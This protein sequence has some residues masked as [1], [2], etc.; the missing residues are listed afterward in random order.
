MSVNEEYFMITM[1]LINNLGDE[2]WINFS[3][4]FTGAGGVIVPLSVLGVGGVVAFIL[5]DDKLEKDKFEVV[6]E[7]LA[8]LPLEKRTLRVF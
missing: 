1:D 8:G 6:M 4:I 3:R 2:W 5:A 7:M